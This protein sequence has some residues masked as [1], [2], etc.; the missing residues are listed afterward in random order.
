MFS[1]TRVNEDKMGQFA[2]HLFYILLSTGLEP[3]AP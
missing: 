2:V 1:N 3:S